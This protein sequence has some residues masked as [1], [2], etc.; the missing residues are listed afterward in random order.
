MRAQG[1]DGVLGPPALNDLLR[2][3]LL[4]TAA[5]NDDK[6]EGDGSAVFSLRRCHR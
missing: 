1:T 3:L 4:C 5:Q 6:R 2:S